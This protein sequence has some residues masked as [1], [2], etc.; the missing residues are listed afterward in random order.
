MDYNLEIL[1]FWKRPKIEDSLQARWKGPYQVLITNPWTAKL[2]GI[3]S[4]IHIS[5]LKKTLPP[6]WT[7]SPTS[8]TWF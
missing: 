4:W 3:D 6:E 5:I 1:V 2:E 7:S 8:D